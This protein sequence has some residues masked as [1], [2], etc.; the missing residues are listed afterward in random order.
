MGQGLSGHSLSFLRFVQLIPSFVTAPRTN[1]LSARGP[2]ARGML[3]KP[4]ETSA[5][6]IQQS[7][8]FFTPPNKHYKCVVEVSY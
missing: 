4:S 7:W 6:S 3:P 2:D 8:L 1:A 5:S